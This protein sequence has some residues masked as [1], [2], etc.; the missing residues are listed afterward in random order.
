MASLLWLWTLR[1]VLW[2]GLGFV[3]TTY[4]H[5][6]MG[7]A[8]GNSEVTNL[9]IHVVRLGELLALVPLGGSALTLTGLGTVLSP[10]ELPGCHV[11][12]MCSHCCVAPQNDTGLKGHRRGLGATLSPWFQSG[13]HPPEGPLLL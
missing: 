3:C 11:S 12:L 7:P 1:E 6:L 4:R 10:V 13:S 8:F 2:G 9:L 5:V